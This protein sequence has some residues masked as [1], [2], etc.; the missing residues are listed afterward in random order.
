MARE[1]KETMEDKYKSKGFILYEDDED[2]FADLDNEE[3]GLL[4]K[5]LFGYFNRGEIPN[6]PKIVKMPFNV[7]KKNIDR[8]SSK[9]SDLVRKRSENKKEWWAKQKAQSSIQ[10]NTDVYTI[11]ETKTKSKTEI[12]S[13]AQAEDLVSVETKSRPTASASLEGR[14]SGQG[15]PPPAEVVQKITGSLVR[16]R[17]PEEIQKELD[18][19]GFANMNRSEKLIYLEKRR[20]LAKERKDRDENENIQQDILQDSERDLG[21]VVSSEC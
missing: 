18:A 16:S 19:D 15:E 6:L 11:K 14:R 20:R 13:K 3:A 21:R 8:D 2:F 10:V 7:I 1:R 17:T 9:Y 4:I 5:A 12:K